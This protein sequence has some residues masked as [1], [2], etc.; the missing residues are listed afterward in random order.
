M[1]FGFGDT[2]NAYQQVLEKY[3]KAYPLNND[4]NISRYLIQH[5]GASI[6]HNTQLM[7]FLM[8]VLILTLPLN[9]LFCHFVKKLI[10]ERD[11]LNSIKGN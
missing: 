8:L 9:F 7:C 2:P 5:L 3:N 10:R 4:D 6:Q 1:S 11:A